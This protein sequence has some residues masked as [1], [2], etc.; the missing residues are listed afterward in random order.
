VL[1][2]LLLASP[3]LA[4]GR[5]LASAGAPRRELMVLRGGGG[6]KIMED[7]SRRAGAPEPAPAAALQATV[8]MGG[9]RRHE[10]MARGALRLR[11]GRRPPRARAQ[12]AGADSPRAA[13]SD[14]DKRRELRLRKLARDKVLH[15]TEQAV[16]ADDTP[17]GAAV[18]G[19]GAREG[20]AEVE[21]ESEL[22]AHGVHAAHKAHEAQEA[23]EDSSTS[24]KSGDVPCEEDEALFEAAEA[25]D[26]GAVEGALANGTRISMLARASTRAFTNAQNAAVA[27]GH[28]RLRKPLDCGCTATQ[29]TR[30]A[31][32]SAC[33]SV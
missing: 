1:L 4:R 28:A 3:L 33:V 17:Q 16:G 27:A 19:R 18:S 6:F 30:A 20:G 22:E 5:E 14:A 25:G 23:A 15:M 32:P 7:P 13:A 11:G 9:W 26:M 10:A 12:A 2:A 29:Q 31:S 21:D 8:L 24:F